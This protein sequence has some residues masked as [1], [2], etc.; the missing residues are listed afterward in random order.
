MPSAQ[1]LE[2]LD[3][4]I[5]LVDVALAGRRHGAGGNPDLFAPGALDERLDL[6]GRRLRRR[7]EVELQVAG[8]RETPGRRADGQVSFVI[9]LAL[10]QNRVR[11]S[12]HGA[13]EPSQTPVTPDGAVGDAAVDHDQPRAGA[14]R[15]AIEVGPDFGFHHHHHR[16]A[17]RAQHAPHGKAIIEWSVEDSGGDSGEFFVG[18]RPAGQGPAT[19]EDR[20]PG[21]GRA[22]AADQFDRGNHL[23][24]RNG[25]QPDGAEIRPV[26]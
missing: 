5:V 21:T 13:E 24:D 3:D 1:R 4:H 15:L 9:A 20:R 2:G 14:A 26:K 6:G 22:Q 7:L 23:A 12:E 17:Q 19:H 11:L 10:R 16:R 25:V 8:R 18:Q